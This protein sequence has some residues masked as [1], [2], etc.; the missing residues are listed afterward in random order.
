MSVEV[1]KISGCVA[2]C[3]CTQASS[4]CGEWGLL[5][6][7]STGFRHMGVRSC[8]PGAHQRY[9]LRAPEHQLRSCGAGAQLL[10]DMWHFP[11][12]GIEPM[13]LALAGISCLPHHQGSPELFFFFNQSECQSGYY[14]HCSLYSL[15]LYLRVNSRILC[16]C[17]SLR[18]CL[19]LRNPI[20]YSPSDFSVHGIFQ[21]RILE[22]VAISFSRGSS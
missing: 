1:F 17:Q 16:E 9:G 2:I 13:F 12:L 18:H 7:W 14:F 10:H 22:W 3:C 20:D 5:S 19:T 4:S 6:L 11:E 21:A 15:L 8:G